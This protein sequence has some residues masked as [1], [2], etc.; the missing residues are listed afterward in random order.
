MAV[1]LGKGGG[2]GK[3]F[4]IGMNMSG[5]STF[6]KALEDIGPKANAAA[7]RIADQKADRIVERAKRLCPDD[8]ETGGTDLRESI[9]RSK[10]ANKGGKVSV[11]L[12]AGGEMLASL[13]SERGKKSPGAYAIVVHEDMT[14]RHP[15]GGQAKFLEQPYLEEQDS[16]ASELA[17]AVRG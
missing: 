1:N 3:G 7:E 5:H 10:L 13:P 4:K 14:M 11:L 16:A 15:H 17:K 8:P 6:K 9:R 12:Q 2:G